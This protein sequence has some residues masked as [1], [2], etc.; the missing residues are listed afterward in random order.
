MFPSGRWLCGCRVGGRLFRGR[1]QRHVHPHLP[2]KQA[3]W[4]DKLGAE[5][6]PSFLLTRIGFV[7]FVLF[8]A[9]PSTINR[10]EIWSKAAFGQRGHGLVP[11]L[12]AQMT[13]KG[14]SPRREQIKSL[15]RR[16]MSANWKQS[17]CQQA[18]MLS[19]FACWAV[20]CT[21]KSVR[22]C[23]STATGL[24]TQQSC[25]A[26]DACAVFACNTWD[27]VSRREE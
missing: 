11:A 25:W 2:S 7:C 21:P 15:H 1:T 24:W 3:A 22:C 4:N 17:H 13:T 23:T 10:V 9:S 26:T 18:N 5:P 16:Y 14:A 6:T 12:P 20:V 8:L 19:R 27:P